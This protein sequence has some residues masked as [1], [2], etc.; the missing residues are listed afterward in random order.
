ME[1]LLPLPDLREPGELLIVLFIKTAILPEKSY[2]YLAAR[3]GVWP[4]WEELLRLRLELRLPLD[5]DSDSEAEP[6]IVIIKIDQI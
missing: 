6:K 3:P 5:P 4:L 1:R 2:T